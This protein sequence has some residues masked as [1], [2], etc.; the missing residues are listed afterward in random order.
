MNMDMV[1]Q[2]YYNVQL[3]FLADSLK[4]CT[5]IKMS[6]YNGKPVVHIMFTYEAHE[7]LHNI[8]YIQLGNPH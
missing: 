7:H 3:A 8:I 5:P 4:I 2:L 1:W 6:C